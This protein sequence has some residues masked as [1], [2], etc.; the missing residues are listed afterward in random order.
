[1]TD[2]GTMDAVQNPP[3]HP[4]PTTVGFDDLESMI[5]ESEK[6]LKAAEAEPPA[7]PPPIP[8]L[9]EHLQGKTPGE[10]ASY[11]AGLERSLKLSEE[12]RR[13]APPPTPTP[14]P[15]PQG[16]VAPTQDQIQAAW[17]RDPI[18]TSQWLA[19]HGVAQAE[20][21]FERRL[22]PLLAGLT[23]AGEMNA[24]Q[25]YPEEFE[26][27][28]SEIASLRDMVHDKSHLSSPEAWD[29]IVSVVRGRPGNLDKLFDRR[30][31]AKLK[32][33]EAAQPTLAEVQRQAAS[34]VPA[35]GS[36][37]VRRGAP[38]ATGGWAD[39]LEQ[40]IAG[41]LGITDPKVWNQWKTSR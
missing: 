13:S 19:Q 33:R 6:A 40:E 22:G 9:P 32:E 36:P 7:A 11:A 2:P 1:M 5:A 30:F 39:P 16:P 25:R 8:G 34:S 20:A 10:L 38:V 14:A 26:L 37:V 31:E 27:F 24:R 12:A 23:A 35:G 3:V 29:Q 41:N 28:G 4:G 17:D 15:I 21:Q 18:A